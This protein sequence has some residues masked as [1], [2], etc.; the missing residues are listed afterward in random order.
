MSA[1]DAL[2][3]WR[4]RISGCSSW[5]HSSTCPARARTPFTFQ[6]VT[7]IVQL[8]SP[9]SA[10]AQPKPAVPPAVRLP[11]RALVAIGRRVTRASVASDDSTAAEE[12]QASEE[13]QSAEP[14]RP[15]FA[16]AARAAS[17]GAR[18][19]RHRPFHVVD[20]GGRQLTV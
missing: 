4:Q 10:V 3:S 11:A 16:G 5:I 20:T 8:S 13:E 1:G 19:P 17:R 15:A 6:V 9:V 14:H 18:G 12:R 2:I 7:F